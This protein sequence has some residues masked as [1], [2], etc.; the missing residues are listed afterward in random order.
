MS[1]CIHEVRGVGRTAGLLLVV[2]R[3]GFAV[4][5]CI[6]LLTDVVKI[7]IFVGRNDT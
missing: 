5:V 3:E 7:G 2:V 1:C 4:V 6:M